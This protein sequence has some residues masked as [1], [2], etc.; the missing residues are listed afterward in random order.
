[1]L[2]AC[3]DIEVVGEASSAEGSLLPISEL[4]PDVVLMDVALPGMDGINATRQIKASCPSVSVIGLTR[5]DDSD[6]ILKLYQAGASAYLIKS[7]EADHLAETIRLVARGGVIVHPE[8]AERVVAAIGG[9]QVSAPEPARVERHGLTERE[10]GV[11]K[12]VAEGMSNKQIGESL[13]I[14]ARTVENHLSNI[15]RK[16]NVNFRLQAAL[17]AIRE[18]LTAEPTGDRE[19]GAVPSNVRYIRAEGA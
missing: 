5:Y 9:T 17:Y 18:G 16:L 1:L 11:L 12:L 2:S 4:L 10:I 6:H 7:V 19:A 3:D 14:S 8:I 15:L 13:G